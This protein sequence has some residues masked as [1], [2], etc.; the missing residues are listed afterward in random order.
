[1]D[2]VQEVGKFDDVIE[3]MI[4]QIT[5]KVIDTMAQ[6]SKNII[7]EAIT[8]YVKRTHDTRQRNYYRNTKILLSHYSELEAHVKA[9]I[10]NKEEFMDSEASD[11]MTDEEFERLMKSDIREDVFLESIQR[12]RTRTFLL[13]TN[14][15]SYMIQLKRICTEKKLLMRYKML[16]EY[17]VFGY[18]M[19]LIAEMHGCHIPQVSVWI[20][21]MV[22]MLSRIMFGHDAI[23]NM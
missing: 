10:C 2:A 17:Y 16:E 6:Q 21:D 22:K 20:S 13:L 1:M 15:D 23:E 8:D 3:Y 18:T 7:D 9:S 19:D 11:D 5:D 12:S 4:K 14:I